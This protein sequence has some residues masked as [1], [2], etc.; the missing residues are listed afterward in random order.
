MAEKTPVPKK[1]R[2][3]PW[4]KRRIYAAMNAITLMLAGA[5]HEGGWH[6]DVKREDLEGA[7]QRL[8]QMDDEIAAR[9][10]AKRS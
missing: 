6:P 1:P 2:K 10:A 9:A 7:L 8:Q 3:T 5:D 4:T